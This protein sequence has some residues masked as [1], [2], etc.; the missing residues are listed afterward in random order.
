M[1]KR[2]AAALGAV[3]ELG[4]TAAHPADKHRDLHIVIETIDHSKPR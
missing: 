3:L 2:C 1:A 4:A